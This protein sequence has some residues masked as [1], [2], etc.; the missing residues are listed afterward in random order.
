MTLEPGSGGPYNPVEIHR[1]PIGKR[2]P[3]DDATLNATSWCDEARRLGDG[4]GPEAAIARL[5]AMAAGMQVR[6]RLDGLEPEPEVERAR[7][8][9]V[10]R[11][12][13]LERRTIEDLARIRPGSPTHREVA[14]RARQWLG[15]ARVTA[16]NARTVLE[17]EPTHQAM[18]IVST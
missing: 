9:V 1:A 5:D 16:Q 12:A 14:N 4:D 6:R 2:P 13:E 3:L 18:A 7:R 15:E 17:F 11:L 8:A 10:A